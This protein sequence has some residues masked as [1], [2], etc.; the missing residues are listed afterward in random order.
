VP[1]F[2]NIPSTKI[3][4][5]SDYPPGTTRAMEPKD[6]ISTYFSVN[7][8]YDDHHISVQAKK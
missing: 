1:L 7:P 2:D 6:P 8:N 3:L 4:L 5:F